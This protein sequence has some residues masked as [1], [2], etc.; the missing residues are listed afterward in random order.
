MPWMHLDC[1]ATA[2]DRWME[3]W[4]GGEGAAE[5]RGNKENKQV[6]PTDPLRLGVP[7]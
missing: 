4:E 5:P 3:R 7:D 2:E 6:L 1:K